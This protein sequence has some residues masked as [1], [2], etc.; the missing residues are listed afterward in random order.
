ME[1][2]VSLTMSHFL[3]SLTP[4]TFQ[5]VR[6]IELVELIIGEIKGQLGIAKGAS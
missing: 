2:R 4:S 6:G 1:Q 5:Q 3:L